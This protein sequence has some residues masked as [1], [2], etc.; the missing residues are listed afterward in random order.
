M[1]VL[2]FCSLR[3]HIHRH[4]IQYYQ[5]QLAISLY[6]MAIWGLGVMWVTLYLSPV[7][8]YPPQVW[9]PQV[10]VID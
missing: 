3:P 9:C 1:I 5:K 6:M 8:L 2:F 4:K 7:I 10:Q